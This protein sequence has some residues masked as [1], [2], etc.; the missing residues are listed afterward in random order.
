MREVLS[1]QVGTRPRIPWSRAS[2]VTIGL[3]VL[4]LASERFPAFDAC[5]ADSTCIAGAPPATLEAYL[6]LMVVGVALAMC[7][8]VLTL[9]RGRGL[10]KRAMIL[11]LWPGPR[12]PTHF[13]P[14]ST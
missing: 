5:V 7:G 3:S 1:N 12:A 8:V 10:P 14:S 4:L 9:V 6:A 11:S 13:K 2:L